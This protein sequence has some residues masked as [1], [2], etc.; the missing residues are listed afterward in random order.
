[1]VV[2]T[3]KY[4]SETYVSEPIEEAL[5]A[6]ISFLKSADDNVS[7]PLVDGKHIVLKSEVIKRAVFLFEELEE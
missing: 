4:D 6:V 2:I 3:V 5:D 7:F 1:M